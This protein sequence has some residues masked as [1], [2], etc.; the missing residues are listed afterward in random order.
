[1]SL[2]TEDLRTNR[3]TWAV[4]PELGPAVGNALCDAL[5]AEPYDPGF[6]GQRLATT[7]L[8]TPALALRKARR[9]RDRYLTLRVRCYR[10]RR[11]DGPDSYALSAKTEGR[12]FRRAITADDAAAILGGDFDALAALLPADLL[13][14]LV[15]LA[16]GGPLGPVVTVACLRFAVEDE[17][18][19]LTLDGDV[20]T[21]TGKRLPCGVLEYKST[22]PAGLAPGRVADLGLRPI[23]L[24]KFLW[25][26][27]V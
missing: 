25:A 2:P 3:A 19:R 4:P 26:T 12:K 1:M 16:G 9:G 24:S 6:D 17:R 22:G 10:P 14:R 23:K 27:E 5:P 7:Y 20:R 8:D 13:A 11:G 21:D 18:D 15:E